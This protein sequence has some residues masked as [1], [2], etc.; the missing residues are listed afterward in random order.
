MLRPFFFYF[1]FCIFYVFNFWDSRYRKRNLLIG[2]PHQPDQ[3][4]WCVA[5]ASNVA[6]V[7]SVIVDVVL[8]L[9]VVLHRTPVPCLARYRFLS[10]MGGR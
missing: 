1:L 4:K 7:V 3:F 10:W 5:A 9:A 8:Y 6:I 2:Q